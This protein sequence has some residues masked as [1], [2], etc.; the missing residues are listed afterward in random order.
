MY[1][2][3]REK[4]RSPVAT[5]FMLLLLLVMMG[6]LAGLLAIYG[7]YINI[8]TPTVA[9]R[10]APTPTPTRPAVLYIADGD[11]FFA[12]GKLAQAIE[13]YEQAIQ[14]DPANDVPFIRQARLLVYTRDTGKAVERAAQAVIINPDSPENLAYYCRALDWEALYAEAIDACSCGIELA[15][16]YAEGYAF[17]SEVHADLGN[18]RLAQS[19]ADLALAGLGAGVIE[20]LTLHVVEPGFEVL[21]RLAAVLVL[22]LLG[23]GHHHA[24]RDVGDADD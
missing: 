16:E 3:P 4:K 9:E 19:N 1:Y 14:K 8:D 21:H 2:R 22:A 24:G 7:G 12:Q 20:G 17:L 10:F 6:V 11:E 13:S 15:P 18:W 5:A 23:A